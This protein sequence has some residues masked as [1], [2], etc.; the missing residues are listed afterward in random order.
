MQ[1]EDITLCNAC[2]DLVS[3]KKLEAFPR[4]LFGDKRPGE[5]VG[6][7]AFCAQVGV[8]AGDLKP[9]LFATWLADPMGQDGYALLLFYDDDSKWSMTAQYNR[10]RLLGRA[11][12]DT[13]VPP[14]RG[15]VPSGSSPG[16]D[17][18]LAG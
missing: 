8:T 10:L 18:S 3:L 1:D 16:P 9:Q 5:W 17:Q 2:T 11:S 6:V 7:R 15:A 14:A 4:H 13:A 12:P